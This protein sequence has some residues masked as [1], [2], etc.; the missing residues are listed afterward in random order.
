MDLTLQLH[1]IISIMQ[2]DDKVLLINIAKKIVGASDWADDELDEEDLQD[3]ALAR[4]ESARGETV[5]RK[6]TN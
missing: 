4:Q 2:D 3:I 5:Y 6:K 1:E